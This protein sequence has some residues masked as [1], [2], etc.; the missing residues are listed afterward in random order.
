VQL[1][2]VTLLVFFSSVYPVLSA[3]WQA[4][5]ESYVRATLQLA[6]WIVMRSNPVRFQF[7]CHKLLR[8]LALRAGG[9][10][11]FDDV[12]PNRHL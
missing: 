7:V 8:L 3:E 2:D 12:A 6:P 5:Q 1:P 11:R 4:I 10:A 9:F